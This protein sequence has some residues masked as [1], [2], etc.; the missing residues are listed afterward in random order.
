MRLLIQR[1][2]H[3]QVAVDGNICGKIGKGLLVFIGV[4][5]EDTRQIADK[6][7]KKLLGLRIFEDENG[8]NK[9]V[10]GRCKRRTSDD[11][12]VYALCRL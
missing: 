11:F 12:P 8:E 7:L 6:Y 4:G 9:P 1:V 3:A 10:T 2:N 5:H